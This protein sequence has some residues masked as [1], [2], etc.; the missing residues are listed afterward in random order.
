MPMLCLYG[1]VGRRRQLRR[2]EPLR[3][4]YRGACS[5]QEDRRA[6]RLYQHILAW[7]DHRD[8]NRRYGPL[9]PE[10]PTRGNVHHRDEIH[11]LPDHRTRGDA[12]EGTDLGD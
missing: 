9:F 3:R 6:P 7:H 12:E 4:E 2:L 10:E 5:G 1:S 11:R 8:D